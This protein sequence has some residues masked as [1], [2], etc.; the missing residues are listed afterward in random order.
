MRQTRTTKASARLLGAKRPRAAFA[1]VHFKLDEVRP[2]L[3]VQMLSEM[4]KEGHDKEGEY[5][6]H[7]YDIQR[8]FKLLDRNPRRIA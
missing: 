8:A 5:Q 1:A 7:D 2:E 6:L 4:P 3:L